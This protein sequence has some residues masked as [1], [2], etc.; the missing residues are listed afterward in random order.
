MRKSLANIELTGYATAQSIEHGCVWKRNKMNPEVPL[1]LPPTTTTR[2][3]GSHPDATL[4]KE[5]PK[6]APNG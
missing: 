6:E 1:Q 4:T 3:A 5:C 2:R